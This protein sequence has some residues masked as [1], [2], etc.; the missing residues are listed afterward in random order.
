MRKRIKKSIFVGSSDT[1]KVVKWRQELEDNHKRNSILFMTINQTV[2]IKPKTPIELF[3]E[4][5][6]RKISEF[7]QSKKNY[8][9]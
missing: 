5:L 8:K 9:M 6:I 4:N 1:Q 3:E 7:R 2:Q